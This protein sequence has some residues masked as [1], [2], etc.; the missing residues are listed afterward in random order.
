MFNVTSSQ[1]VLTATIHAFL[2]VSGH[3]NNSQ[4]QF[5]SK[6]GRVIE[7]KEDSLGFL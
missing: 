7:M 4:S 3:T 2:Q 1:L 5:G 6:R